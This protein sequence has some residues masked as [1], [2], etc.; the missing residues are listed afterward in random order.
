MIAPFDTALGMT[1]APGDWIATHAGA[2]YLVLEATLVRA[3]VRRRRDHMHRNR[4]RL[5]CAR[6]DRD[7]TPPADVHVWWLRWYPRKHKRR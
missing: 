3:T 5:R 6:L 1:V 2:R 7:L 4:H